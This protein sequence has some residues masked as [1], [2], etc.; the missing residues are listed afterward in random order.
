MPNN[1]DYIVETYEHSFKNKNWVGM[2]FKELYFKDFDTLSGN[3][4]L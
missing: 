2:I 1:E 4:W 3:N